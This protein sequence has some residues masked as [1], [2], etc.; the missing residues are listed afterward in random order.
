MGVRFVVVVIAL[1]AF[2]A[3]AQDAAQEPPAVVSPAPAVVVPRAPAVAP[4][5]PGRVKVIVLDLKGASLTSAESSALSSLVTVSL[6]EFAALE[7]VSGSDVR[8]M[9]ELEGQK[10]TLGCEESMS[11]LAEIAGALGARLVTYG[12]VEKLGSLWLLTMSMQ[13]TKAGRPVGRVALQGD[14]IEALAKAVPDAVA[15]M[16]TP[17]LDGERLS[18]SSLSARATAPSLPTA[19]RSAPAEDHD[20]L[21]WG[22]GVIGGLGAVVFGLSYLGGLFTASATGAPNDVVDALKIPVAGKPLLASKINGDSGGN[23]D[24]NNNGGDQGVKTLLYA[25]GGAEGLAA[26][27]ALGGGAAFTAAHMMDGPKLDGAGNAWRFGLM[28]GGAGLAAGGVAFDAFSPSSS[29]HRLAADD[30]IT[31]ACVVVGGLVGAVGL[32]TNP[33]ASD[34]AP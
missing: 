11:C 15:K 34:E 3:R 25:V 12:Q 28:L 5:E 10:Q 9:L 33:F 4:T 31:P 8:E 24:N 26:A 27:S 17:F 16:I 19:R 6:S 7:V 13:D 29:D 20:G 23:D 1:H 30:F 21:A 2:G 14:G 22:G 32:L 18:T